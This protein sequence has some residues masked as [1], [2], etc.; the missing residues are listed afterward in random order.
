MAPE[1]KI[2]QCYSKEGNVIC[3]ELVTQHVFASYYWPPPTQFKLFLLNF[4]ENPF[5]F[6][7]V[8]IGRTGAEAEAPILWPPGAKNQF[9]GKD[10]DAGKD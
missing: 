10:P 7:L 4:Q 6:F 5:F 1:K 8:Y 2:S 9:T 3:D